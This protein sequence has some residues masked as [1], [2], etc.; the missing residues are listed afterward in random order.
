MMRLVVSCAV[1]ALHV[2]FVATVAFGSPCFEHCADDGP[3]GRCPPMCATCLCVPQAAPTKAPVAVGPLT[4]VPSALAVVSALGPDAP[5]S[6]DIFH[7]PKSL[8]A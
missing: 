6:C 4:I 3:D 1:L 8:L 7:V 5:E 2:A